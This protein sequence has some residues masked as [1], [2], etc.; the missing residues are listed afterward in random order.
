MA[1]SLTCTNRITATREEC[2]LQRLSTVQL[3]QMSLPSM[4]TTIIVSWRSHDTCCQLRS[5]ANCVYQNSVM[6]LQIWT[7]RVDMAEKLNYICYSDLYLLMAELLQAHSFCSEI[8]HSGTSLLRTPLG[9]H[10]VSII[11]VSLFESLISTVMYCIGTLRVFLLSCYYGDVLIRVSR[12]V[13]L[14]LQTTY[15][16]CV[17]YLPTSDNSC[18]RKVQLLSLLCLCL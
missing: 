11:K 8:V 10:R 14:Y 13:P 17:I 16:L 1:I 18:T 5:Q 7:G 12:F 2:L 3:K 15:V 9:P 6:M 4:F